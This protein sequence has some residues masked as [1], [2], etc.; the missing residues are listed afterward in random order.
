M[1]YIYIYVHLCRQELTMSSLNPEVPP[2]MT[3]AWKMIVGRNVKFRVVVCCVYCVFLHEPFPVI[4]ETTVIITTAS[5]YIRLYHCRLQDY[6][7]I[8]YFAETRPQ[9]HKQSQT[10]TQAQLNF[11][12]YF[13]EYKSQRWLKLKVLSKILHYFFYYLRFTFV[14]YFYTKHLKQKQFESTI[15]HLSLSSNTYMYMHVLLN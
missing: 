13:S 6:S 10:Q 9:F 2:W 14:K 3:M 5:C 8:Q 15:I 4:H 12:N 11:L 1:L 7:N